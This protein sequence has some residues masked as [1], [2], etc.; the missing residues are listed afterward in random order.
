MRP[1]SEERRAVHNAQ[2]RVSRREESRFLRQLALRAFERSLVFVEGSSRNLPG[3]L[4]PGMT[5]LADQDRI[6]VLEI[7]DDK[8]RVGIRHDGVHGL[9]PIRKP[10][11][12]FA[13]G[14][15]PGPA[16]D[17]GGHDLERPALV[18]V[19]EALCYFGP[20]TAATAAAAAAR[21]RGSGP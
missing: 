18:G 20:T 4:V 9:G 11:H 17:G 21:C 14:K 7:R 10:N 13:Q 15:W 12:V 5:P 6:A 19:R 3:W 1:A 16:R 8:S 2:R